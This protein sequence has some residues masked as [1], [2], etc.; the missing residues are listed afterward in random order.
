M[1]FISDKSDFEEI[2]EQIF[3]TKWGRNYY[4]PLGSKGRSIIDEKKDKTK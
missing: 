1:D 4:A 3:H 2:V